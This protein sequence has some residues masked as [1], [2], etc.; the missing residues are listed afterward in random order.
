MATEV[1]TTEKPAKPKGELIDGLP[2]RTVK[3]LGK[4]YK[5][6]M[7]IAEENDSA[8]DAA[9]GPDG[10][11]N[12]RLQTR[13]VLSAM[14]VGHPDLAAIAKFPQPVLERLIDVANEI[15]DPESLDED[16]ND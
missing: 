13:L 7:L 12:G 16:P 14:I 10:T 2:G 6:R 3:L 9:S 1:K 4:E 8:R 5:L 15:N 11:V